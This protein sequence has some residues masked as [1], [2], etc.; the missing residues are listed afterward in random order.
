MKKAYCMYVQYFE[1]VWTNCTVHFKML[2]VNWFLYNIILH[3]ADFNISSY[4]N[5]KKTMPY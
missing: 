3:Y 1:N 5:L 2:I 4:S